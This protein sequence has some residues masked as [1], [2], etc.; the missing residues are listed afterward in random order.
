MNKAYIEIHTSLR[1]HPRLWPIFK[2]MESRYASEQEL[3]EYCRVVPEFA[4]RA[5]A[6]FAVKKMEEVVVIEVVDEIFDI[7]PMESYHDLARVKTIRDVR[8]VS[9]YATQAML[10]NDHQWFDDKLLIWLRTIL[11]AFEFPDREDTSTKL[12]FSE[13]EN[14]IHLEKLQPKQRVIY[15]TYK[16]LK[17]KYR[18][19]LK[20]NLYLTMESFLQQPV[21]TLTID[22]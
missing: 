14:D 10:M 8:L 1:K 11:Q 21:D 5:E 20:P 16:K 13:S 15:S 22:C 18:E 4:E 19:R 6:S 12:L 17:Q 3:E 2:A 7:Y 9:A